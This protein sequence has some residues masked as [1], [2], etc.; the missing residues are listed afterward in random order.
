MRRTSV[1]TDINANKP[2]KALKTL[3]LL[4][5][6]SPKNAEYHYLKAFCLTRL[7]D[8]KTA[9]EVVNTALTLP[10]E[11]IP[12]PLVEMV[13][14]SLG[15]NTDLLHFIETIPDSSLQNSHINPQLV[16]FGIMLRCFK[17][18]EISQKLLIDYK[19]SHSDSS[20][21]GVIACNVLQSLLVNKPKLIPLAISMLDRF[22]FND[23]KVSK[24]IANLTVS[25]AK[26]SV[27]NLGDEQ[28][29]EKSRRILLKLKDKLIEDFYLF[30]KIQL[31]MMAINNVETVINDLFSL[32]KIDWA[33]EIPNWKYFEIFFELLFKVNS[34]NQLEIL[35]NFSNLISTLPN[36]SASHERTISLFNLVAHKSRLLL[37]ESRDFHVLF[38]NIVDHITKFSSKF[39][40]ILEDVVCCLCDLNVSFDELNLL[41]QLLFQL[42]TTIKSNSDL[43][44]Y[45]NV[46]KICSYFSCFDLN[47]LKF[48]IQNLDPDLSIS[49]AHS[50]YSNGLKHEALAY[51][52]SFLIGN[53][54][55]NFSKYEAFIKTNQIFLAFVNNCHGI[56][57]QCI[58]SLQLKFI[59]LDSL[60]FVEFLALKISPDLSRILIFINNLISWGNSF[61][62]DDGPEYISKSI[63][64][65]HHNIERSFE[66]FELIQKVKFSSCR[67]RALLWKNL[68]EVLEQPVVFNCF[69]SSEFKILIENIQDNSDDSVLQCFSGCKVFPVGENISHFCPNQLRYSNIECKFLFSYLNLLQSF[70]TCQFDSLIGQE[71]SNS[72]N[73]YVSVLIAHL[74]SKLKENTASNL[75]QIFNIPLLLYNNQSNLDLESALNST[76]FDC[77]IDCLS[78]M[79]LVNYFF[80]PFI[81]QV[82]IRTKISSK[83]VKTWLISRLNT[84]K[85]SP[86]ISDQTVGISVSDVIKDQLSTFNNYLAFTRSIINKL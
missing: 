23:S 47:S 34:K 26:M 76:S 68:I 8:H 48:L 65:D 2:E 12:F 74:P 55:Q 37:T 72:I 69:D 24:T 66:I 1:Y 33:Q 13:L 50:L 3:N 70:A 6:R 71:F 64:I 78:W 38:A 41:R 45:Q 86:Q 22:D 5:Q 9:N 17:F 73:S 42:F 83:F 85:F 59:Q 61:L 39:S 79:F 11:N 20:Y 18:Q 21:L 40:M 56:L 84:F 15:R 27:K 77:E 7:N 82:I 14:K 25:I 54:D 35:N 46:L 31:E 75:T 81:K 57:T 28:L 67:L 80:V 60:G 58:D 30:N 32:I 4:L 29:V 19:N 16:R 52:Q 43:K 53:F 44:S 36:S 10:N 49:L 51:L 62:N 63:L